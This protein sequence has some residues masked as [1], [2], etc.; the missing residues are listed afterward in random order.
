MKKHDDI[1]MRK[2]AKEIKDL[3][4]KNYSLLDIGASEKHLKELLPSNIDYYSL[5][6]QGKHDF[7]RDLNKP[8]N[9]DWKIDIIVCLETLE[10]TIKPNEVMKQILQLGD[11]NTLFFFSM[12]NE[13]NFYCRLNFLIGRKTSVQE[14]FQLVEKHLHIHSPRVKDI[15]I[16]F[17]KYLR[18]EEVYF[19]WYSRKSEHG[20]IISRISFRVVDRVLNL[21]SYLLPSLFSRNVLIKGKMTNK[22]KQKMNNH[23]QVIGSSNTPNGRNTRLLNSFTS[24][25]LNPADV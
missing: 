20:T 24:P 5:D 8:L 6:Y 25:S 18:I 11:T 17:E 19:C 9:M 22:M 21:F 16:F 15:I 4:N 23:Q 3:P 10:H 12:P 7:L 1:V 2:V 14:S 13:Y